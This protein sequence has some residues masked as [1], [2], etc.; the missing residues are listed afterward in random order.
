MP[1]LAVLPQVNKTLRFLSLKGNKIGAIN[2]L[3]FLQ[4]KETVMRVCGLAGVLK[5]WPLIRR[6][7]LLRPG[8]GAGDQH[9]AAADQHLR[10]RYARPALHPSAAAIRCRRRVRRHLAAVWHLADDVAD[11][12]GREVA[13]P[14]P[15][16][17]SSMLIGGVRNRS[18]AG[19]G[20]R[21]HSRSGRPCTRPTRRCWCVQHH[22]Q[23]HQSLAEWQRK[24]EQRQCV[25]LP[26]AAAP[27]AK[28]SV[29]GR[30][31]AEAQGKAVS[32]SPS[33]EQRVL[34]K[35]CDCALPPALE[36]PV[37][38]CHGRP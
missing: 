36:A 18:Q 7:G 20:G 2:F 26:H 25:S 24:R 19:S 29:F 28:A 16:H 9:H 32:L 33:P 31:P 14:P 12:T 23:R 34:L 1:V 11:L 15:S 27:R 22:A 30:M 3:F 4:K 8:Q 38:K 13:T 21:A 6:R 35:E 10:Q 37:N 17:G 5:E